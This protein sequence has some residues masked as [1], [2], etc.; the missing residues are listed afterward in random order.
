MALCLPRKRRATSLATRP[1]TLSV[2]STTNHSCTTSAGFALKVEVISYSL[3]VRFAQFSFFSL[4]EFSPKTT[5]VRVLF[6]GRCSSSESLLGR[7]TY[8]IKL[9]HAD[10]A[11]P[12]NR[13]EALHY[14]RN[15]EKGEICPN[16]CK[17]AAAVY[18][19]RLWLPSHSGWLAVALHPQK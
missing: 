3:K 11:E 19:G 13:C 8:K 4:S 9:R 6:Y 7:I 10:A 2:A 5:M 1:R 15:M 14:M 17:R 18:F 12:L 16:G